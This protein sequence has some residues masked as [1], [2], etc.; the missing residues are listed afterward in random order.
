MTN[1]PD[2][3]WSDF[4]SDRWLLYHLDTI[5]SRYPGAGTPTRYTG[6]D[7]I[8]SDSVCF[9]IDLGIAEFGRWVESRKEATRREGKK[10]KPLYDNMNDVLGVTEEERRGGFDPQELRS[11]GWDYKEAVIEA[12]KKG[13]PPPDIN[14]WMAG[15]YEEVEDSSDDDVDDD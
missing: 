7:R 13:L 11:T 14:E 12:A 8:F 9:E 15:G 5:C 10:I 2:A 3:G 4:L 1:W 6:L